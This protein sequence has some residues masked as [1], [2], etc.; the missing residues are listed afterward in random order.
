MPSK[1]TKSTKPAQ[2]VWV[3]TAT[4]ESADHYGPLVYSKKPSHET[5]K[6][7]AGDWDAGSWDGPGNYGSYCYFTVNKVPVN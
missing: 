3:V 5:L 2:F 6:D 7:L 4:S 1:S